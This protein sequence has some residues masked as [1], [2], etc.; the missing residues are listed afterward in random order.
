MA[1]EQATRYSEPPNRTQGA[2]PV[3]DHES[4]SNIRHLAVGIRKP[5]LGMAEFLTCAG[6]LRKA[7]ASER[8]RGDACRALRPHL[9]DG[10]ITDCPPDERVSALAL[11]RDSVDKKTTLTERH[12]AAQ[13]YVDAAHLGRCNSSAG[14]TPFQQ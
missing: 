12:V 9:P 7:I 1:R 6:P 5:H 13:L 3:S 2:S 4:D 10:D 11:L 8:L 14:L